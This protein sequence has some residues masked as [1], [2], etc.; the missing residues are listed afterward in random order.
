MLVVF[1]GVLVVA[2][3]WLAPGAR[4]VFGGGDGGK[5][6]DGGAAKSSGA[7]EHEGAAKADARRERPP[8]LSKTQRQVRNLLAEQIRA[9]GKPGRADKETIG[10]LNE[11]R[12]EL[13][14]LDVDDLLAVLAELDASEASLRDKGTLAGFIIGSLSRR[15]PRLALDTAIARLPG[16][17]PGGLTQPG[18]IYQRWAATDLAAAAEWL[19]QQV[20]KGALAEVAIGKL[21]V[22]PRTRFESELVRAQAALDPA[23]AATRFAAIPVEQ[24]EAILTDDWFGASSPEQMKAV[25]EFLREHYEDAP[26]ALAKAASARIGQGELGDAEKF[27][28]ALGPA[29]DERAALVGEALRS[30]VTGKQELLIT[31]EEARE[32]IVKQSPEDAGR[33]TGTMLGQMM[34]W[35]E[36]AELSRLAL[37]YG[38]ESGSDEVLVTFLKDA[39][40]GERAELNKAEI[41]ALAEKIEDPAV[42]AEVTGKFGK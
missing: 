28:E 10:R 22:T 31:P 17:G 5:E 8:E 14:R 2:A 6:T 32:W 41:L 25:A 3:W 7:G 19:D 12:A 30:R 20:A 27:L 29:P 11:F 15:D 34:E 9:M 26:S 4:G 39:S 40:E 38:E 42:R 21:K 23:A 24:R 37:K 13:D 18:I 1:A 16:G 33:L 35:H 36:F